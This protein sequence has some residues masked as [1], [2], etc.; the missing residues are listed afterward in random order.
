MKYFKLLALPL[1]LLVSFGYSCIVHALSTTTPASQVVSYYN[2]VET[3]AYVQITNTNFASTVN[4]HV[5]VLSENCNLVDFFDFLTLGDTVV[6]NID[7]ILGG[8]FSTTR[9]IVIVNAVAASGD[10]N[11]IAFPFLIGTTTLVEDDGVGNS[12]GERFAHQFNNLGRDFASNVFELHQPENIMATI[13]TVTEYTEGEFISLAWADD[14]SLG[15]FAVS[16]TAST[17]APVVGKFIIDDMEVKDSCGQFSVTCIS[18][19][20]PTTGAP[21]FLGPFDSSGEDFVCDTSSE[22]LGL[23]QLLDI[24]STDNYIALA[25][26][27]DLELGGLD[28][29]VSVSAQAEPNINEFVNAVVSGPTTTIPDTS[30]CGDTMP[31][32]AGRFII[33]TTVTN[34]STDMDFSD[35]AYS[36]EI[37]T[38]GNLVE[39]ADG[40]IPTGVGAI[41]S[42]PLTPPNVGSMLCGTDYDDGIIGPGECTDIEITVCLNN[43]N[44]FDLFVDVLGTEVVSV[45]S[46]ISGLINDINDLF[47]NTNTVS[48]FTTLS[49]AGGNQKFQGNDPKK[50][51][52]D[53]EVN[54][55]PLSLSVQ[56]TTEPVSEEAA[57]LIEPLQQALDNIEDGNDKN[58]KAICAKLKSF[59]RQVGN[60]EKDNLLTTEEADDLIFKAEDIKDLNGCK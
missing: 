8:A 4:I 16:G 21:S 45:M 51:I 57:I 14:Y 2:T 50:L 7:S 47:S 56:T 5:Q 11:P 17:T 59:I 52:V 60:Y 58:N 29:A 27:N 19:L 41:L 23:I 37:L 33:P 30:P 3:N 43:L 1:M 40:G 49:A 54:T 13:N 44:S 26:G 55:E 31:N 12:A 53:G 25:G 28:Y 42:A 18:E 39:N 48:A 10:F 9:G 15:Y 6:Y 22:T 20:G 32:P 24:V 36:I 34:I 38:N 46:L 35:I